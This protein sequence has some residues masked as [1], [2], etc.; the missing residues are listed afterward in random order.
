MN[1]LPFIKLQILKLPVGV[2]RRL[3]IFATIWGCEIFL[4]SRSIINSNPRLICTNVPEQN[5]HVKKLQKRLLAN[6]ADLIN[7]KKLSSF[8]SSKIIQKKVVGPDCTISNANM[9]FWKASDRINRSAVEFV[10]FYL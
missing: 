7:H 5:M 9:L 8:N 2:F 3:R 4:V 10:S 1:K 6:V